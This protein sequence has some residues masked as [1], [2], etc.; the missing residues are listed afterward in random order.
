MLELCRRTPMLDQSP[1]DGV[2]HWRAYVGVLEAYARKADKVTRGMLQER[3]VRVHAELRKRGGVVTKLSLPRKDPTWKLWQAVESYTKDWLH[4][5]GIVSTLGL[6][7]RAYNMYAGYATPYDPSGDKYLNPHFKTFD[8]HHIWPEA[9]GGE[10][11]GWNVIPLPKD[12]HLY[13]L[14]PQIDSLLRI[15]KPG[16]QIKLL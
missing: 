1:R 13:R 2:N 3:L 14:H 10:T 11:V 8:V 7:E 9:F 5:H 12:I 6:P 4:R 16:T 15:T